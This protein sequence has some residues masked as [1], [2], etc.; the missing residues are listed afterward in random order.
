MREYIVERVLQI[1]E[2][3]T[4]H[5]VTVREASKVFNVSKSTVHKD[6]AERLEE[7]DGEL[8]ALV[9]EVLDDNLKERH[10]RGGEATKKKYQKNSR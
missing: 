6:M 5:R 4:K 10:I 2:Y 9:R 1:G 8:F 7:V 3:I